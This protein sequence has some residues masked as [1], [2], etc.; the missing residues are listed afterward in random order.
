MKT[1]KHL[2]DE[3]DCWNRL[4]PS[5]HIVT[6]AK[7]SCCLWP[8]PCLLQFLLGPM[9]SLK[10]TLSRSL[11]LLEFSQ[12]SYPILCLRRMSLPIFFNFFPGPSKWLERSTISHPAMACKH[13]IEGF[14]MP[15]DLKSFISSWGSGP[16]TRIGQRSTPWTPLTDSF[17]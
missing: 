3:I 2:K 15:T 12:S 16:Q 13:R 14:P 9:Y 5:N 10:G 11:Q 8:Y 4:L 7:P 6:Q 17:V 1:A